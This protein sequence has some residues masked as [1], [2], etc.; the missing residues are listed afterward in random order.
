MKV[1]IKFEKALEDKIRKMSKEKEGPPPREISLKAR[2]TLDGNIMIMDHEDIDIVIM[3][4][5]GKIIAFPKEEHNQEIYPAQNR[6][7]KFLSKKGIIDP[8]TVQGG[9]IFMSMEGKM[10][11]SEKHNVNQ[12]T[13]LNIS[14]FIDQEKPNML[15]RK[16]YEEEEERRLTEPGP[17]D[18]TEFDPKRHST[19]KGSMYPQRPY[20]ISNIYR[21]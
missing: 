2:K 10:V 15:I 1:K 16:A 7:F 6:L 21:M 19:K 4:E 14:K 11:V 18:S 5:K 20:G 9:N 12:V 8:S 17:E 13:L 3:P